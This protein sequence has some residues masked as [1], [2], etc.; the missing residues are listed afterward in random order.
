ML[1]HQRLSA[2]VENSKLACHR[3]GCGLGNFK[4]GRFTFCFD[5]SIVGMT[6]APLGKSLGAVTVNKKF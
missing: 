6:G 3:N 1:H 4:P 2:R 5:E